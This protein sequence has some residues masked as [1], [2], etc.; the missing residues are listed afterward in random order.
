MA[1]RRDPRRPDRRTGAS[2]GEARNRLLL[3][4][5]GRSPA[6]AQLRRMTL[7]PARIR[8]TEC[9]LSAN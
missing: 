5:A 8:R 2:D 9:A 1:D 4:L 3:G 6:M 7:G